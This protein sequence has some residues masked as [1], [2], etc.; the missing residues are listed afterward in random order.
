MPSIRS[1]HIAPVKSLALSEVDNIHVGS[2]GIANDRRFMVLDSAGRV[3]SQ[4]Q[5]GKL[6]Q[7]G[8]EYSVDS[9]S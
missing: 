8:S 3:V 5:F 2:R 6:T 9:A 4:R 7:V 1:I